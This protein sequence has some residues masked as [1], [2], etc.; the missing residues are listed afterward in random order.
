MKNI[1][2]IILLLVALPLAAQEK[3]TMQQEA[4]DKK[5]QQGL[6]FVSINEHQKALN[7][8]YE[9][10]DIYVDGLHRA[11]AYRFIAAIYFDNSQYTKAVSIYKRL[12]EEFPLTDDGMYG[13]FQIGICYNKMGFEDDAVKAFTQLIKEY[14]DSN[15]AKDASTM[16][17]L[18]KITNN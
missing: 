8:F 18:L 5:F 17:E 7:E 14:P 13:L 1:I 12:F 16:I 15:Y 6:F 2:T 9:Y 11:K 3:R 4:D 10:L